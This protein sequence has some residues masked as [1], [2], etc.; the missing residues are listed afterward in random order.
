MQTNRKTGCKRT[1]CERSRR[2]AAMFN[3][4]WF[5]RQAAMNRLAGCQMRSDAFEGGEGYPAVVVADLDVGV[6]DIGVADVAVLY[7]A[8]LPCPALPVLRCTTAVL[9]SAPPRLLCAHA[10][11]LSASVS[12]APPPCTPAPSCPNGCYNDYGC[13]QT[14]TAVLR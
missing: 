13:Q 10:P 4:R 7:S 6:A 14:F 3:F 9:R 1:L 2:Q 5:G 12:P 11:M 8:P